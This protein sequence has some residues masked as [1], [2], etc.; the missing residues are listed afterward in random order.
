M[1][2]IRNTE[3]NTE[4]NTSIKNYHKYFNLKESNQMLRNAREILNYL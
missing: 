2:A 4:L 1:N 3:L